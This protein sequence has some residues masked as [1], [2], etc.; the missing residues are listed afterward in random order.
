MFELYR[1]VLG[2]NSRDLRTAKKFP[3]PSRRLDK[4]GAVG[5]VHDAIPPD[6][7]DREAR[8]P[9]EGWQVTA[10]RVQDGAGALERDLSPRRG[11]SLRRA[12]PG[13]REVRG[14][15]QRRQDLPPL[16]N[17]RDLRGRLRYR[18]VCGERRDLPLLLD[19]RSLLGLRRTDV[20]CEK[21]LFTR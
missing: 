16:L 4:R 13:R 18:E 6:D 1:P 3:A 8:L 5:G 10:Q 12:R 9:E 7:R 20:H 21:S 14:E 15:G 11:G 17:R 19:R 2:M